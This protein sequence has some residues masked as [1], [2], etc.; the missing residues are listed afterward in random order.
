[1][2]SNATIADTLSP[3]ELADLAQSFG[4]DM[5]EDDYR[6]DTVFMTDEWLERNHGVVTG[7]HLWD[8]AWRF[9]IIVDDDLSYYV[10]DDYDTVV[11]TITLD[12]PNR[13]QAL[14]EAA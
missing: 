13:D 11:S 8:A 5:T 3:R 12:G 10:P 9:G 14:K 2:L 1:M 7:E 4:L 6:D